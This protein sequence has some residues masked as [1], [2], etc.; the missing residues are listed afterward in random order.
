MAA[1]LHVL[2]IFTI[3]TL[4][5]AVT[6]SYTV[7]ITHFIKKTSSSDS[8]TVTIEITDFQQIISIALL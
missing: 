1:T 5:M 8:K 4:M 3:Q 2:F 7:L 6:K